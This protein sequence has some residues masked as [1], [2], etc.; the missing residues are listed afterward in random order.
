MPHPTG[1][2]ANLSAVWLSGEI[3]AGRITSTELV[4]RALQSIDELNAQV[5]AFTHVDHEG[6]LHAARILDEELA[7]GTRRSALHGLPVA[8]KDNIDTGDQPTTYGSHF[9]A[10]HQPAHDAPLVATLREMGAVIIGKTVTSEFALGPTGEFSHQGGAHNPHDLARVSGGSSAGSA[11]AVAAGMV[12]LAVGTDTAGSVRIPAAFCGI[13]G[14]K[15]TYGRTSLKGVFPVSDT[16][17]Q[18]GP[19]AKTVEDAALLFTALAGERSAEPLGPPVRRIG[20]VD[21]AELIQVTPEISAACRNTLEQQFASAT[22]TTLSV[23]DLFRRAREVFGTILLSEAYAVHEERM[24][25]FKDTF[26]REQYDRLQPG[27]S[28]PAWRYVKAKKEAG[29]LLVD[30]LGLFDTVDLIALPTTTIVAPPFGTSEVTINGTTYHTRDAINTL[31]SVWSLL[32]LPAMSIPAGT[33]ENLPCGLQLIAAPNRD[34]W[35]LEKLME[36]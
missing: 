24:T 26:S 15:P 32:G 20:W 31:T 33:V 6:A 12:P 21:T 17:D 19:L 3:Q 11:A 10:T 1:Y 29:Q 2:F 4:T 23:A 18:V 25:A 7:N 27:A 22:V 36:R 16:L 14:L 5:N 30:A 13:V 28:I 35:L 9:F 34:E 8:I